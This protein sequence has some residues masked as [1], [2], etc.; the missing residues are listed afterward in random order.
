M[1]PR[2]S[3]AVL[4]CGVYLVD[5]PSCGGPLEIEP[6][7]VQCNIFRHG[8]YKHNGVQIP[9]HATK[10]FCDTLIRQNLII[11][12]GRPFELTR[13]GNNAVGAVAC[14]W[15]KDRGVALCQLLSYA[16][17]PESG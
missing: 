1:I 11:G 16:D 13:I 15:S 9:P 4:A 14:D 2:V 6:K 5:C 3:E 8:W 7:D 17:Q 10:D 12:C